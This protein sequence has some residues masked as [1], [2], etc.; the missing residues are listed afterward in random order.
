MLENKSQKTMQ[1]SS[2]VGTLV[3]TLVDGWVD[4]KVVLW[5]AYSNQEP[6]INVGKPFNRFSI[7]KFQ[8]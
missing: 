3:I 7:S 4:I 1:S 6:K 8:A 2:K 5:I